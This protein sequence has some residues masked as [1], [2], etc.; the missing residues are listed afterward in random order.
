MGI[1]FIANFDASSERWRVEH[2]NWIWNPLHKFVPNFLN[3]FY[4]WLFLVRFIWL[5]IRVNNDGILLDWYSI[6]RHNRHPDHE[7]IWLRESIHRLL[8]VIILVNRKNHMSLIYE[9]A[10]LWL[11]FVVRFISRLLF[12]KKMIK[13]VIN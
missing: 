5:Y 10:K 4:F 12:P 2:M 1:H 13:I 6:N 11:L 7:W 9:R 3:V 8:L